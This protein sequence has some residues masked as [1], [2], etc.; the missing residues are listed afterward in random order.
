MENREGVKKKFIEE[1]VEKIVS[2]GMYD[3]STTLEYSLPAKVFFYNQVVEELEKSKKKEEG[4]EFKREARIAMCEMFQKIYTSYVK[5]LEN[6]H[7]HC[8]EVFVGNYIKRLQ[9]DYQKR[10]DDKY[11]PIETGSL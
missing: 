6:Q 4:D 7:K 9:E 1:Y 3:V 11:I 10:M 5:S 2:D 8:E